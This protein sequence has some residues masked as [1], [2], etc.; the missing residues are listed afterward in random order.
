MQSFSS[1][2]WTRVTINIFY[3][4]EHYAKRSSKGVTLPDEIM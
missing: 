1:R 4:D 3:Y 2:I